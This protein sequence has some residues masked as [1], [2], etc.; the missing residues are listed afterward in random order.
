MFLI[1]C[2]IAVTENEKMNE[3]LAYWSVPKEFVIVQCGDC[4]YKEQCLQEVNL[5]VNK[6]IRGF[7]IN[8]C[9]FGERKEE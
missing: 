4:K 8:Y 9:S 7:S 3:K 6:S 5:L 1:L 2:I